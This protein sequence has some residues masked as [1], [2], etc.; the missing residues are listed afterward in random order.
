MAT[1]G[2][3]EVWEEGA[4][5]VVSSFLVCL[6]IG[7]KVATLPASLLFKILVVPSDCAC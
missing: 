2:T 7:V 5:V 1:G 6:E 4:P 3:K